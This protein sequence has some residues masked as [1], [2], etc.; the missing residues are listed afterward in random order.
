MPAVIFLQLQKE[1][2]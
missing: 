2:L 1:I